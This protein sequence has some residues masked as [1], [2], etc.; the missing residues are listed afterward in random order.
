MSL[1]DVEFVCDGSEYLECTCTYI[2][3]GNMHIERI[4]HVQIELSLP[5]LCIHWCVLVRKRHLS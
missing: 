4:C 2:N 1:V 5:Q 3:S